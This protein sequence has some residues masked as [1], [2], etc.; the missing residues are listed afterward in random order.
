MSVKLL[1]L[2]IGFVCCSLIGYGICFGTWKKTSQG[3]KQ[4]GPTGSQKIKGRSEIPSAQRPAGYAGLDLNGLIARNQEIADT[5]D[6]LRGTGDKDFLAE[7]AALEKEKMGI[8]NRIQEILDRAPTSGA[9][10]SGASTAGASTAGASTSKGES[11]TA[12]VRGIDQIVATYG[13]PRSTADER[14]VAEQ[15]DPRSQKSIVQFIPLPKHIRIPEAEV[16]QLPVLCQ[17]PHP[18][19]LAES[20]NWCGYYAAFNTFCFV[21]G[22]KQQMND[23]R[24]FANKFREWLISISNIRNHKQGPRN[25]EPVG[26][27]DNLNVEEIQTL[28]DHDGCMNTY[29]VIACDQQC[30]Y[31]G[32]AALS[33]VGVSSSA[34]A[35]P[36]EKMIIDDFKQ[37][38]SDNLVILYSH[39]GHWAAIHV[40][41][42]RDNHLIFEI[43]DSLAKT[44]WTSDHIIRERIMPLYTFLSNPF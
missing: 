8:E 19:S 23:R 40:G 30:S 41:R 3:W 17:L 10:T 31:G 35:D 7:I 34:G 22:Q 44:D 24:F 11:K 42:D 36:I 25:N 14:L 21:N 4:E 28:L 6:V 18:E 27:Y 43:A 12:A 29:A 2:S 16:I 5:I 37:K 9:S 15:M 33:A 38:N 39:A 1:K 26:Y 32:K 20:T 13:L